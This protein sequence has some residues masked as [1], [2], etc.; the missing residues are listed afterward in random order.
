M[1][2]NFVLDILL[3]LIVI[4]FVPIGFWRGALKEVIVTAAILLGAA[5]AVAWAEP[6]GDSLADVLNVRQG[7]ARFIVAAVALFLAV[8]L[9]GYGGGTLLNSWE[10]GSGTR[11]LGCVLAAV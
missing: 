1:S 7:V 10:P 11:L 2:A 4:L 8:I 5:L 3:T 9:L 6:W